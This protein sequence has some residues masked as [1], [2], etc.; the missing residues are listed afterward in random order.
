MAGRFDV[1]EQLKVGSYQKLRGNRISR[2]QS[3]V[4]FA[5]ISVLALAVMLIGIQFALIGQ[6]ALAVSQGSAALARYAAVNPGSLG[7]NGPAA[8]PSAA[9]ALLSSSINDGNLTVTI[10]SYQSDGVTVENGT[11]VPTQDQVKISLSYN[12]T[13]KLFLPA[14]TLLGISFPTTLTAADS[15]LYE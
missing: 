5:L 2:G 4:E 7:Q 6:T 13:N 10:A 12:A 15:A 3:A 14:N 8:M 1:R 9:A 11:I